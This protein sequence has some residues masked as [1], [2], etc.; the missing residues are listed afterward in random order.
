MAAPS[1]RRLSLADLD[2]ASLEAL[3]RH[4]EDLLV[5]R[6]R[7]LPKS[8]GCGATVGS[9]ANTL[10]GWV[11]IGVADDG[12]VVGWEKPAWLDLQSHLGVERHLE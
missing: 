4:G 8:P 2:Q 12:E 11:V 10:G 3:I 7:D 6:T 5:E 9:F 1:I